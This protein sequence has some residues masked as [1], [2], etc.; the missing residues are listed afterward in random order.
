MKKWLKTTLW[1]LF[2]VGI[3]V[4]LSA[5]QTAIEDKTVSNRTI[6]IHVT[7]ENALLNKAELIARLKHKNLLFDG[8]TMKQL[9]IGKIEYSIRNMEEVK[10]V[11]VFNYLNGTWNI[12]VQLRKPIAH[13]YNTKD[14]N[15]YICEDGEKISGDLNHIARVLIAT[16]SISDLFSQENIHTIIN[17][18]SLKTIRQ[19][20]EVYR[21]SNYV[22]ND[23][24][25]QSFIG[26]IHRKE[27]GDFVLIPLVGK[28][29]IVFGTAS[30][31][32]E[33]EKKFE[34]LKVFYQ[35]AMPYV[36]WDVYSEISLKYDEQIVC[37][38]N[39]LN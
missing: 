39:N 13:V 20:D 22:C 17:N 5:I 30:S 11:S 4:L 29:K 9:N 10:S 16:G 21:I 18:D 38:R 8:Q 3:V 15:F 7:D 24:L 14:E 32:Q 33:V 28:Q 25:M 23:P 6:R 31:D 34:K 35:K 19:L 26:Q 36:G 1:S 2:V 27:N 37:R 12:E